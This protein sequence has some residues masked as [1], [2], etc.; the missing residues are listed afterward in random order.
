VEQLGRHP[1]TTP[2]EKWGRHPPDTTPA[3]QWGRHPPDT[4]PAEQLGRHTH[5]TPVEQLVDTLLTQHP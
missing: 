1:H 4:T 2:A 5:T 3:E